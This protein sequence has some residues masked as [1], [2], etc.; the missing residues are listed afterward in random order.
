MSV[1][2]AEYSGFFK[3]LTSNQFLLKQGSLIHLDIGNITMRFTSGFASLAFAVSA[4]VSSFSAQAASI[5]LRVTGV[6]TPGS[7]N[8]TSGSVDY[9]TITTSD[10]S[11]STFNRLPEKKIN[12]SV[13]CSSPMKVAVRAVDNRSSTVIP[14]AVAS[15]DSSLTDAN[16][17]GLG[18]NTDGGENLGVFTITATPDFRID[19]VPAN[20][21][22]SSN[23]G[24]LWE[25]AE[26]I[27]LKNTPGSV[28]SWVP[29]AGGEILP[30]A[31]ENLS[32]SF[33]VNA[34][35]N[36]VDKLGLAS[37]VSLDGLAT[38]EL[39]YL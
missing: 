15:L 11:A 13:H 25:K 33:T 28:I 18:P 31:F 32:G 30:G 3:S 9:G 4:V 2:D 19:G 23:K 35:L 36:K 29:S 7:C 1:L 21:L 14:G 20:N 27:N 26:T 39:V 38:L 37:D 16:A 6:I 34:L 8:A 12:F 10:L 22:V 17:F 5:D 24:G